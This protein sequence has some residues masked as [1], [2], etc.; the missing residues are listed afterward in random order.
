M[1][2]VEHTVI[3]SV[4]LEP[5]GR[6]GEVLVA[7]V[8]P[9]AGVARRCSRCGR[10]CPGYDTSPA[11]RRRRGLDFG[12]TQVFLQATTPSGGVPGAWGGGRG[13]A[14]GAA[15]VA[16]HRSVRG[17]CGVAGV[18]R[19]AQRGSDLVAGGVAQRVRHRG[20]GGRGPG[21]A[22]R[23]PRGAA[24]DRDRRDLLPLCG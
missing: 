10:R 21:R 8:R 7:R 2:G 24:P 22:D 13:G 11:P 18:S 5:D 9:K 19:H 23:P 14:V 16:V 12:T 20:L 4:D 1:L 3:E 6:D 17:Q 15:G